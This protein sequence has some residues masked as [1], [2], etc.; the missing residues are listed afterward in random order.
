MKNKDE[1]IGF[2]RSM[3]GEPSIKVH[4][5]NSSIE[6][7]ISQAL[8]L[9][10]P[11]LTETSFIDNVIPPCDLKDRRVLDVIHVYETPT[12]M[13]A[14]TPFDEFNFT[15]YA[16]TDLTERAIDNAR[17]QLYRSAD[18]NMVGKDFRYMDGVLYADDYKSP[19]V[20]EC[21]VSF[22]LT[23]IDLITEEKMVSFIENYALASAKVIEGLIRRKYTVQGAPYTM[24]GDSLVT[25]GN[26]EKDSLL[27]GLKEDQTGFFFVS[28]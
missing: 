2:I 5:D 10:K 4:I 12:T 18:E 23:N 24:D 13:D 28:R 25:E 17:L 7:C 15:N 16:S 9:A 6:N 26:T 22:D 8:N 20:A 27:Q 21:I 1:L 14:L 19:L 3:L 11:Y